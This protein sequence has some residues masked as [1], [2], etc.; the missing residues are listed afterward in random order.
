MKRSTSAAFSVAS[1]AAECGLIGTLLRSPQ[2][3]LGGKRLRRHD[4]EHGAA[5]GPLTQGVDERQLIDYPAAGKIDQDSVRA[6]RR[7][8]FC[9]HEPE[10]LRR[11]RAG[12]QHDVA[13]P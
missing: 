13:G 4:I 1:V 7:E 9:A 2:R 12:Q 5:N 3:R 11:Q 10:R 6:E 8:L